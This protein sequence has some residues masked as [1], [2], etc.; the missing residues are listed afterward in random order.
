MSVALKGLPEFNAAV[1]GWFAQVEREA[2][3]AATGLAKQVFEKVLIESPQFRGDF[4]ANWKVSIGAPA[5]ASEF[6][7]GVIPR[8]YGEHRGSDW[9]GTFTPYKRGDPE[10]M[11]YARANATWSPIRLGQSIF[12]SN[13]AEHDEYYAWKIEEGSIKFRPVN[14]GAGAAGR[15]SVEFVQ[16]SFA[17]IGRSQFDILRKIGT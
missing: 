17:V 4:V 6:K 10:G 16:R 12:I 13:S 11:N 7:P 9:L 1:K 5:P 3:K 8:K 2:A 15:R 14:A